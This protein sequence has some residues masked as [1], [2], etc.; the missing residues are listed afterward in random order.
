M[1][2]MESQSPPN[3]TSIDLTQPITPD[4]VL[5]DMLPPELRKLAEEG[6]ALI[7]ELAT[8]VARL[9]KELRIKSA[10]VSNLNQ[11]LEDL[12]AAAQ[13]YGD[14]KG[15]GFLFQQDLK[16][17]LDQVRANRSN[18]GPSFLTKT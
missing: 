13:K 10:A 4:P 6:P 2:N 11:Q 7:L 16:L 3:A 17:C 1:R 15:L 8:E 18:R 14:E 9:A 12:Q 5:W